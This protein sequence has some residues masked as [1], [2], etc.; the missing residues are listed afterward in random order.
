MG[1]LRPIYSLS[2]VLSIVLKHPLYCHSSTM[3]VLTLSRPLIPQTTQKRRVK[4]YLLAA[5]ND[6]VNAQSSIGI[7]HHLL[8]TCLIRRLLAKKCALS[9]IPTFILPYKVTAFVQ[10]M[11]S[12]MNFVARYKFHLSLNI[13]L[14]AVMSCYYFKPQ[15]LLLGF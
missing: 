12:A 15:P 2:V 4:W 1:F 8:M 6:H 3:K 5:N 14:V 11:C 7:K 10:P 13:F 9:V